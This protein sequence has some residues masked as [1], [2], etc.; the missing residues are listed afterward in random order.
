MQKREKTNLAFILLVALLFYAVFI[1]R[2]SF[3]IN[4]ETYFTLIDDAMISMRYAKHLAQGYGFVWNIGEPPVQG[5][6]NLGWTLYMAFLHLMP[7]AASR[8]SL[9]VM[10]TSVLLLLGIT[11]ISY[12]ICKQLTPQSEFGPMIAATITAFYYP[13]VF[14]SLR[15]MEVGIIIFLVYWS[16]LLVIKEPINPKKAV[17]IGFLMAFAVIVRFDAI[18]QI[19]LIIGYAIYSH[20][21][22]RKES[23]V[24]IS[25][26]IVFAGLGLLGVLL[27]QYLY[28]GSIFPNTYY[29]KVEGVSIIE[30]MLIGLWV[31]VEY[32]TRDFLAL[33]LVIIAGLA[34]F[35]T[36]RRKEVYLLLAMFAIQCAYSIYVGGDYAEPLNRPE[37][38]AANRFITQ[39]MPS[40]FI[41]FGLTLDEF[42]HSLAISRPTLDQKSPY[43]KK[44]VRLGVIMGVAV[45][46]LIS[47]EPWF[48]WGIYNAP[49]WQADIARAKA[50]VHIKEHT[51][52]NLVLAAHAAG[53]IPYYAER[54]T[55]DLYGK[56]DPVVAK[57]P[58]A[59]TFR[60]GHNKWDYEYSIMTLNPDLI[61][62]GWDDLIEFLDDKEGWYRLD[63][64]LWVNR[65]SHLPNIEGLS[66]DF[67][68]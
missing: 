35:S 58:P 16:V 18:P 28:F 56:S 57:G 42:V 25:P 48:K 54:A 40:I 43:V 51:E 49:L 34:V 30:R 15:G 13:L 23:L 9:L 5:F 55:V 37:V 10:I 3:S 61:V 22:K 52:E 53:Q 33:L 41:L 12:K 1:Y 64:G 21:I 68:E 45:L 2:T 24:T 66:Q 46:L 47:G 39:G 27:F 60:P 20:I 67:L 4:G 44:T 26:I 17:L 31:F 6:T 14:W 50:G 59:T 63:N 62:D 19:A 32:A 8:I 11:V 38:D 29:L 65:D 36:L 7:I